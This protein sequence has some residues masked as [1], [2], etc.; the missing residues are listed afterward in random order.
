[1]KTYLVLCSIIFQLPVG[2]RGND[3]MNRF[4]WN[5]IHLTAVSINLYVSSLHLFIHYSLTVRFPSAAPH[6]RPR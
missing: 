4:V 5:Q 6:S 3:Q 2:R 1:M